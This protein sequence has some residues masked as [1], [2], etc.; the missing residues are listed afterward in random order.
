[1][2]TSSKTVTFEISMKMNGYYDSSLDVYYYPINIM[3]T[4]SDFSVQV[5]RPGTV[6]SAVVEYTDVVDLH[7]FSYGEGTSEEPYRIANPTHLLNINYFTGANY[8]LTNNIDLSGVT[9]TELYDRLAKYG[10]L[11][12]GEFTGII[13]GKIDDK[14]NRYAIYGLD[15][16]LSGVTDF[17]LFGDLNGAKIQNLIFGNENNQMNLSN[18]FAKDDTN[19]INL[20]LIATGANNSIIE[21]IMVRDFVITL[22]EAADNTISSG[23]TGDMYIAGLV[24][25]T[26]NTDIINANVTFSVVIDIDFTKDLYLGGAIAKASE[27]DVIDSTIIFTPTLSRDKTVA[28]L[29]GIMG[30]YYDDDGSDRS[31]GI[32]GTTATLTVSNIKVLNMGGL[33]GY[34]RYIMITN[35]VSKGTITYANISHSNVMRIGG[36]VGDA[37]SC[38]I[39]DTTAEIA[40]NITKVSNIDD[41]YIG[42]LT[43]T[44]SMVNGYSSEMTYYYT[45]TDIND[46]STI[47][48]SLVTLGVAGQVGTGVT[49]THVKI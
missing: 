36:L 49:I 26:S 5:S 37:R 28:Y 13:N 14:G 15:Y 3:G 19:V 38:I 24:G 32:S 29:G 6:M 7:L 11:L 23:L 1:L 8:L 2:D 42:A 21:N 22:G 25:T 33:V 48:N 44:V 4:Y 9:E 46:K 17:A 47:T 40:I 18:M 35:S 43:G 16:T 41:K 45:D 34:A 10:A 12:A 20:S 27:T 39:T 30:Y 31:T